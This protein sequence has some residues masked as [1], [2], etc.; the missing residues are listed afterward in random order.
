MIL[1]YAGDWTPTV[2]TLSQGTDV[3]SIIEFAR[4]R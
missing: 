1:R 4:L 3:A 2:G